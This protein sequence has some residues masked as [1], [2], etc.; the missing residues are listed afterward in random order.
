MMSISGIQILSCVDN[1]KI[2]ALSKGFKLGL[3]ENLELNDVSGAEIDINLL[4]KKNGNGVS[5][6]SESETSI[7]K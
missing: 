4:K 3:F 7:E 2:P 5:G 6:F 1:S